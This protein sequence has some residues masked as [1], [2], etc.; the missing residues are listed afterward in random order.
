MSIGYE[1]GSS[2]D[3]GAHWGGP[4]NLGRVC[5]LLSSSREPFF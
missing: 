5:I 3:L 1:S 4:F 2:A